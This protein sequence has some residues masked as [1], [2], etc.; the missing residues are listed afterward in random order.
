MLSAL[1]QL[2][3]SD[4]NM[5]KNLWGS[6]VEHVTSND[7][8]LAWLWQLTSWSLH[9]ST[10]PGGVKTMRELL[11]LRDLKCQCCI[12]I[13]SCNICVTYC[14]EFKRCTPFGARYIIFW[15]YIERCVF[16]SEV[17][18][19]EAFTRVFEMIPRSSGVS[20]DRI[21]RAMTSDYQ[22]SPGLT[23]L[24]TVFMACIFILYDCHINRAKRYGEAMKLTLSIS[25][26]LG[27]NCGAQSLVLHDLLVLWWMLTSFVKIC[28][29]LPF[30]QVKLGGMCRLHFNYSF[31]LC[32]T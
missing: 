19:Y 2:F 24:G 5:L 7:G 3:C 10:Q 11:N 12:K 6:A 9:H 18:T 22:H 25:T 15:P 31:H 28:P 13:I 8:G 14:V 26:M 21:L 17:N 4:H 29:I 30:C 20:V 23:S 16:H 32:H 1:N 27:Q